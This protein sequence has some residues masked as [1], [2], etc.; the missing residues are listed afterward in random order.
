[1]GISN[2]NDFEIKLISILEDE[3][4]LLEKLARLLLKYR[5]IC[6]YAPTE[7]LL[8]KIEKKWLR[9]Y[10]SNDFGNSFTCLGL[11]R[12]SRLARGSIDFYKFE[13]ALARAH[14]AMNNDIQFLQGYG[15]PF[16]EG[17]AFSNELGYRMAS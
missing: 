6:M 10:V 13:I 4:F 2:E 1:M 16:F 15:V 3:Q 5:S 7:L 14:Y 17:L 9:F 8:I 12:I 11:S